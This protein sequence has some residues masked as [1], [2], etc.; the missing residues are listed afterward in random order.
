M[1]TSAGA[2]AIDRR[3]QLLLFMVRRQNFGDD[4]QCNELVIS[5]QG[6]YAILLRMSRKLRNVLPGSL[7]S[8][9]V[10]P[11]VDSIDPL[12]RA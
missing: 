11:V 7:R 2:G 8:I 4:M 3:R 1:A 10:E 5:S 6:R 9:H 12:R